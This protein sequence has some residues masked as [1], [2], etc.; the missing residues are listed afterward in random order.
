MH[1]SVA[2]FTVKL[3]PAIVNVADRAVVPV[4]A[5]TLNAT[6]PLPVPLAP[7]V[8]VTH[9][10]GLVAVQAQPVA[11]VTLTVPVPPLATTDAEVGDSV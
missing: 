8:I 2:W 11:A 9:V 6:E 3:C 1:V 7:L 10:T 4:F 5:A